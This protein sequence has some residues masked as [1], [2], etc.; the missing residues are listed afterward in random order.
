MDADNSPL[1]DS[2]SG[3]GFLISSDGKILTNRHIAQP[4]WRD[5]DAQQIISRGYRPE[6]KSL[7]AY[8]PGRPTGYALKLVRTSGKADL[9]VLQTRQQRNLPAPLLL[10]TEERIM[11][12]SQVWLIGYPAGLVAILGRNGQTTLETI[13]GHLNFTEQQVSQALAKRNLIEPFLSVGHL[14]NV[15]GDVVT[16][17]ALISDG[18]SGSPVLSQ[19]GKVIAIL[20]ASLTRVAGGSLAVPARFG[21]ELIGRADR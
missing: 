5:R 1:E 8:F 14:S 19:Q 15:S 3:T 17:A 11:P 20:S 7:V 13:P 10:E 4:W 6:L 9:A 16:L 21:L 12:G 18:S 2:Y